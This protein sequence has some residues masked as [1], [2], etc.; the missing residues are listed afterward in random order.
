MCCCQETETYHH[1][2]V[3]S[4]GPSGVCVSFRRQDLV[5][6]LEA[7]EGVR[8][9][10]VQYLKLNELGR[11]HD[12]IDRMPFLKRAPFGPEQEFRFVY[13]SSDDRVAAKSYPIPLDCIDRIY[14]SPW[15]P[16]AVVDSVKITPKAIPG[17]SSI[18]ITRSTLILND[19]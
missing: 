4:N 13:E 15:M 8:S 17:V 14:L 16:E 11:R 2:H 9:G 19:Q 6:A 18:P 12:E 7:N 10:E 5:R 3:F 1:W